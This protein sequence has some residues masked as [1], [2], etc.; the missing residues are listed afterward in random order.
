MPAAEQYGTALVQYTDF[1][2]SSTSC[3]L[4]ASLWGHQSGGLHYNGNV[5]L[6]IEERLLLLDLVILVDGQTIA[7]RERH[8]ASDL[9]ASGVNW[10]TAEGVQIVVLIRLFQMQMWD[11][12]L[13][14]SPLLACTLCALEWRVPPRRAWAQSV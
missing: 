11:L 4:P 8:E 10:R 6:D 14:K 12:R 3:N 1:T 7:H 13:V 2:A 9:C 5:H